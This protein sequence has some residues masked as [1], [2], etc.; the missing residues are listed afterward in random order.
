MTNKSRTRCQ[1]F[2]SLRRKRKV[3]DNEHQDSLPT[4]SSTW[5]WSQF[6]EKIRCTFRWNGFVRFCITITEIRKCHIL[7]LQV[8]RGVV[9]ILILSVYSSYT[10][11]SK[12][13]RIRRW[14]YLSLAQIDGLDSFRWNQMIVQLVGHRP[15][16]TLDHY[17]V[18][19]LDLFLPVLCIHLSA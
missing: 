17:S 18:T 3:N 8:I 7:S 12:I 19:S 15:G 6:G 9:E 16:M 14:R 5:R 10:C 2:S 11:T 4:T 13:H 1:L